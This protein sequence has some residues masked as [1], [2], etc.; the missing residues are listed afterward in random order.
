MNIFEFKLNIFEFNLKII[1]INLI[2]DDFMLNDTLNIKYIFF[3]YTFFLT[4]VFKLIIRYSKLHIMRRK[5]IFTITLM[6][7]IKKNFFFSILYRNYY[8]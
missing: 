7:S 1:D 8:F 2:I 6:N 3:D 5:R 4:R